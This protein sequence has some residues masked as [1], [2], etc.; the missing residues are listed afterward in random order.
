M[1]AYE[2]DFIKLINRVEVLASKHQ[3]TLDKTTNGGLCLSP[4]GKVNRT[5]YI[6]DKGVSIGEVGSF[7]NGYD[8]CWNQMN[9]MNQIEG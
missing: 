4:S 5:R 9:Q 3:F 1:I 7:L 8:A 6:F 2:A